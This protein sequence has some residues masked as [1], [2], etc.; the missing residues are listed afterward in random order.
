[1]SSERRRGDSVNSS[2]HPPA[3]LKP[4]GGYAQSPRPS[5]STPVGCG[6]SG[7]AFQRRS[8]RPFDKLMAQ[9]ALTNLLTLYPFAGRGR[10]EV[11]PVNP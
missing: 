7:Q 10:L 5:R 11:Q 3:G 6:R 2:I 8:L 4:V 9:P 1:M